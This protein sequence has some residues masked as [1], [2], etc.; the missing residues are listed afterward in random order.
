MPLN[1][2]FAISGERIGLYLSGA[3]GK[4]RPGIV[5]LQEI[6]GVNDA[7][8]L[9]ADGFASAG[10][11]VA[12]PDLYHRLAPGTALSYQPADRPRALELWAKLR[13]E[14]AARDIAA[15][16]AWLRGHPSCNGR[17]ALLGFC[18]G[19]KLAILAA[20]REATDCVVSFYPVQLEKHLADI[21]AVRCPVQVHIGDNDA[22]VP[23]APREIVRQAL[24][25]GV[26]NEFLVYA[27]AEHGFYNS[28]RASGFHPA[29]AARAHEASLRF[30]KRW[31]AER[32]AVNA[33]AKRASG[34]GE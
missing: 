15:V 31:L 10:F 32:P 6:F 22:H 24:C 20:A 3:G 14:D 1:A 13:D 16:Q 5:L 9:A 23:E 34:L 26:E 19:G 27:G 8:E 7:M 4:P 18:L 28:I 33:E 25:V 11:V 21:A 29:A 2:E 30:L 12:A 17:V